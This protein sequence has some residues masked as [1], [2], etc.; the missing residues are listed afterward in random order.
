[1]HKQNSYRVTDIFHLNP[2][3]TFT[4]YRRLFS[5]SCGFLSYFIR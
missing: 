4:D 5:S 1:M 2:R 3:R